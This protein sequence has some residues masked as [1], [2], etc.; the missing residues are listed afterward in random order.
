MTKRYGKKESSSQD[1]WLMTYSDLL[2]ILLVFL[3]LL[4]SA[5]EMQPGKLQRIMS[6][7]AEQEG[8]PKQSLAAISEEMTAFIE[9]TFSENSVTLSLEDDG[10]KI[11]LDAGIMFDSGSA[12]IKPGV[13]DNLKKLLSALPKYQHNYR[14][15]IEGHADKRPVR[16]GTYQS[17]W[18]LSAYRAI[19]V[20][21]IMEALGIFE[22]RMKVEAYGGTI[23]L[24]QELL[25]QLS[26]EEKL[27]KHRRVVIRVY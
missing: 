14:F 12:S 7:L 23:P 1:L 26:D 21:D 9:T 18:D 16:N 10:L 27:A 24:K 20:R 5:S 4:I 8:A 17:N 22:K 6:Q 19:R 11:R 3:V 13:A 15:A 25:S 2:M